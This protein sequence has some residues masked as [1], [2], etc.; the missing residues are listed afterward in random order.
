MMLL[1]CV[2]LFFCNNNL[3]NSPEIIGNTKPNALISLA[4][5]A[6]AGAAGQTASYPLDIVRRRMQTMRVSADAPEQFPTI[7]ETLAK[8]YRYVSHA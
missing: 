1:D 3:L 7:L 4:F 5:G 6:A 2:G 8:I